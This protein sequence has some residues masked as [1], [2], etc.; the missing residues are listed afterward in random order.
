M[1]DHEWDLEVTCSGCHVTG[2][3]A[4]NC[5]EVVLAP[6]AV[7][8]GRVDREYITHARLFGRMWENEAPATYKHVF[9]RSNIPGFVNGK[10]LSEEVRQDDE[11]LYFWVER[12]PE[13]RA[14]EL[15]TYVA[16]AQ[17]V[18]PPSIRLRREVAELESLRRRGGPIMM[19]SLNTP[20]DHTRTR[21]DTHTNTPRTR[22]NTSTS[23]VGPSASEHGNNEWE[24]RTSEDRYFDTRSVSGSRAASHSGQG[25]TS[26]T[27]TPQN[28]LPLDGVQ[29]IMQ[30]I[31]YLAQGLMGPESQSRADTRKEES[32][33]SRRKTS[34]EKDLTTFTVTD[35][36]RGDRKLEAQAFRNWKSKIENLPDHTEHEKVE[37][38][39]TKLGAD[40]LTMVNTLPSQIQG[41]FKRILEE[42]TRTHDPESDSLQ[43]SRIFNG[44]RQ[45]PNE[46]LSA[47]HT[48]FRRVADAVG[49]PQDSR[50]PLC[51]NKYMTALKHLSTRT[52][53]QNM[54]AEYKMNH[55]QLPQ[56]KTVMTTAEEHERATLAAAGLDESGNKIYEVSM[57]DI[58]HQVDTDNTEEEME[59][60]AA[61]RA[62]AGRPQLRATR[63]QNT[64][65][66]NN[67]PGRN[68][69]R[70]N[71]ADVRGDRTYNQG[72][73]EHWDD[74]KACCIHRVNT[75]G[76]VDCRERN[77]PDCIR[78][79]MVVG[80]GNL[81]EHLKSGECPAKQCFN[82]Q[83]HTVD[84]VKA[85]CPFPYRPKRG[86]TREYNNN[87]TKPEYNNTRGPKRAHENTAAE[88][89]ENTQ[90]PNTKKAKIAVADQVLNVSE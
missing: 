60:S 29:A 62:P 4:P 22:T 43:A 18:E 68:G 70:H 52:R 64:Y 77:R 59:V 44:I 9:V 3:H 35:K 84:H 8:L 39:K 90:G 24:D 72:R 87:N 2:D 53:T 51:L 37:L 17:G 25:L 80:A 79:H 36:M 66:P 88:K 82:C 30:S 89:A 86:G 34:R 58:G 47:F 41:N 12:S 21:H 71:P 19:D 40:E 10:V 28:T 63:H 69:M 5:R 61:Q 14:A 20:D 26:Q 48:R 1:T 65:K 49:H 38:L 13:E 46:F 74:T 7:S 16:H 56:L 42:L 55:D 85:N 54:V 15:E 75:H 27:Q 78:C 33:K 81:P 67:V 50:E 83:R 11:S 76:L 23:R 45:E 57:C 73:R 31:Q 6:T 32:E